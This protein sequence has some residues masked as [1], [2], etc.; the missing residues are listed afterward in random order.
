[1]Q[2]IE[3]K[4]WTNVDPESKQNIVFFF[5]ILGTPN[6]ILTKMALPPLHTHTHCPLL[7]GL[8]PSQTQ[9]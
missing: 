3:N 5:F 4:R 2:P 8:Q 9:G 1:M 7:C 6:Q